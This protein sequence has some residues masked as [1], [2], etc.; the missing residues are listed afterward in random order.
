MTSHPEP[1]ARDLRVVRRSSKLRSI[2]RRSLAALGMTLL[3][4]T[5]SPSGA[6]V[7]TIRFWGMG[8]EGEVVGELVKEFERR[9]PTIHVQVQQIPW[10]AAHEKL[11]TAHVGESTPDIAQLGN[12]W[13]SEFAALDALEP[14]GGRIDSTDYFP[15]IWATNVV[16]RT[17]YGV[18]WYVDTR[19]LFY[20][21]DLLKEAGYDSMPNTWSDWREAM[22]R[23][24]SHMGRGQYPILL[25]TNEWPQ[26]VIFAMQ[27]GSSLLDSTGTRGAF[28]QPSFRTGF[29]FY[30]SLFRD[31]FAP[32]VSASEISNRYQEFERGNIA[33]VITGPWEIGEFGRRLSPAMAG[34]WTTAPLPGPDGPGV[35]FAGGA[36]L[37]LFRASKHK[38][39]AWK[40]LEFLSEP[41]QLV[42]FYALTGNLPPRRSAWRDS[43][44]ATN[45]YT[46]AFREQLERLRPLPA[47]PEI[48]QIVTRVYEAG[49]QAARARRPID[50]TLSALDRDVDGILEK[51][52]WMVS[53][54]PRAEGVR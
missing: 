47:V 7:V 35:S 33:M 19:V 52:R 44:L 37:V 54:G 3:A 26:P 50:Q 48:E 21:R 29:E 15:G 5:H 40:L 13:I 32:V 18:P 17:L 46:R 41:E 38:A 36:S 9:N 45:E 1:K 34:K 10:I 12:T 4:C 31:G 6:N 27:A 25:P 39:E 14:L 53:R 2:R 8:R 16:D 30:I 49:E 43:S 42:R 51:R 24:R 11:L 20:R 22:Q 28:R 23:L